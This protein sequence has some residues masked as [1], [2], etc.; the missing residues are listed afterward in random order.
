LEAQAL[1]DRHLKGAEVQALHL[2]EG[3]LGVP[4]TAPLGPRLGRSLLGGSLLG[5]GL[6]RL[7]VRL[8]PLPRLVGPPA[9]SKNHDSR[10]FSTVVIVPGNTRGAE[11]AGGAESSGGAEAVRSTRRSGKLGD[12]VEHGPFHP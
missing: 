4:G 11:I 2:G 3:V 9:T 8:G 7:R 10:S 6:R 1:H 12:L 5:G